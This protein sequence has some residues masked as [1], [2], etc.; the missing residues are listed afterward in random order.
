MTVAFGNAPV[1]WTVSWSGE[2]Q[3][4]VTTCRFAGGRRAICQNVAPGVGQPRFGKPHSQRQREAISE[5]RCDLCAK[6]LA[7]RTKVSLSHARYRM[8]GAEGMAIMQVEPL[9]HRECAAISMRHCPSLR[10]DIR[11]GTLFVRQVTRSRVQLALMSPEYVATYV[12]R[13]VPDGR[14]LVVGHA[15]VELLAWKD[16]DA[17]W[18][19]A[20]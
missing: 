18:L 11:A 16:R 6:P 14:G 8:N 5:G 3:F 1:P 17:E 4:F 13:F 2:D 15:K 9:L 12:P 19:E 20:A 10:R 7:R